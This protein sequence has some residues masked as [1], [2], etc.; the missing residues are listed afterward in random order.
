MHNLGCNTHCAILHEYLILLCIMIKFTLCCNMSQL[1]S[2]RAS[3]RKIEL[4]HK[5][6]Y[7][8]KDR[9]YSLC[10]AP[11]KSYACKEF[12]ICFYN[13]DFIRAD[14]VCKESL[15]IDIIADLAFDQ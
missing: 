8:K 9:E 11:N 3:N 10:L 12:F 14:A 2:T 4:W 1:I 7:L 15:L 5:G 13:I 6:N